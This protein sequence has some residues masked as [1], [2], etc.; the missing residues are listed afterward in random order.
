MPLTND[1]NKFWRATITTAIRNLHQVRGRRV[2]EWK[3]SMENSREYNKLHH[4][5]SLVGGCGNENLF[6]NCV[7]AILNHLQLVAALPY[8]SA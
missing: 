2:R 4:D 8:K 6:I 1:I 7:L 5:S 3:A